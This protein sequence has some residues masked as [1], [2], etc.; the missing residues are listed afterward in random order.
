MRG[1]PRGGRDTV[2][3]SLSIP[4][5]EPPGNGL[6]AAHVRQ[7]VTAGLPWIGWAAQLSVPVEGMRGRR[8]ARR[9]RQLR[10]RLPVRH[11]RIPPPARLSFL[12]PEKRLHAAESRVVHE[13]LEAIPRPFHPAP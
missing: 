12:S 8:V 13:V 11:R 3:L 5:R 7:G 1:P 9:Q 6:R 10:E 4:Q 2:I